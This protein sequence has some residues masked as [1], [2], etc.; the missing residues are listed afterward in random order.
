[1]AE[2]RTVT[3]RYRDL[4]RTVDPW[5]LLLR[6]GNWY[7][8]G[9][10]HARADRRTFRIDRRQG[11]VAA[12][13]GTT[14]ERPDDFDA[15]AAFATDPALVGADRAVPDARVRIDAGHAEPAIAG[16]GPDRVLARHPDGSVEV[17]VPAANWPALRNW[18]LAFMEHAEIVDPPELRQRLVDWLSHG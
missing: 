2:R 12:L 18:V 9:Y 7:L 1:V 16:L 13:P 8:I 5:G 14:F 6:N 10:D 4:D 3:F 17:A 15:A 11:E